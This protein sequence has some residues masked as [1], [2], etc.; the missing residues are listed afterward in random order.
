LKIVAELMV[1][2][3]TEGN[4]S[5]SSSLSHSLD[6][7]GGASLLVHGSEGMDSNIASCGRGNALNIVAVGRNFPEAPSRFD[8]TNSLSSHFANPKVV[9]F[10]NWSKLE[11]KY[12]FLLII[13]SYLLGQMPPSRG[14]P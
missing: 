1:K 2:S 8:P 7:G 4:S 9:T 3:L 11:N 12:S 10:L 14:C 6:K 13:T 5:T